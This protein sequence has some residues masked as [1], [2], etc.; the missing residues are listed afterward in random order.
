VVPYIDVL[1]NNCY[2]N[3]IKYSSLC[4]VSSETGTCP[5]LALSFAETRWYVS[6]AAVTICSEPI[7]T[8][9]PLLTGTEIAN[10]IAIATATLILFMDEILTTATVLKLPGDLHIFVKDVFK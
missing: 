4:H 8:D 3:R 1:V 7:I 10:N 6:V 5:I 9:E 2:Q